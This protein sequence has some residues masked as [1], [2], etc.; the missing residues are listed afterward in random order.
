MKKQQTQIA[1]LAALVVVAG[2][3][4]YLQSKPVL[5]VGNRQFRLQSY[6]PLPVDNPALHWDALHHAQQ[7][8]YKGSGRNPFLMQAEAAEASTQVAKNAEKPFEPQG[9]R[10]LPRPQPPTWP[11][12]VSFFGYGTVPNG[13]ARRAFLSVDGEVQVVGE[14]DTLLGRY[15]ILQINNGNLEFQDISTGLSSTK[16]LDADKS[17]PPAA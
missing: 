1:I 7:T 2:M 15:R 14:G 3:V 17:A 13:T 11:G 4:W 5:D 9:P 12:N 6:Q 16:A 8:E 10:T